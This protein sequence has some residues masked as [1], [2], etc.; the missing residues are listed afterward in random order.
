M[1]LTVLERLILL[2]ILPARGNLTTMK[3]THDLQNEAGFSEKELTDLDFVAEE[4]SLKWN[5]PPDSGKQIDAG[6][7][8]KAVVCEQLRK[9]DDKELLET[10]HLSLCEKFGYDGS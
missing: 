10:Q 9:L 2:R 7:N 8:V 5:T 4:G 6:S 3:I 1:E